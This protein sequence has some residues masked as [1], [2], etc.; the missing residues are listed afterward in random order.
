MT[1]ID[2]FASEL[3]E[4]A[5]ALFER[6]ADNPETGK[7]Y[8]HA[9]LMLGFCSFEAHINAISD[10]FLAARELSLADQSVLSERELKLERGTF[11]LGALKIHRLED[12]LQHLHATFGTRPVDRSAVWWGELA[13]ATRL[14]NSLTHPRTVPLIKANQAQRALLA[15][16]TALN[17]T[18]LSLYS[19]PFPT[20]TRGIQAKIV[21]P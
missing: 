3:L 11:K 9:S 2:E 13:D 16:I 10:D 6:G 15:I 12:R 18:Y 4:E 17:E 8:L 7:A 14:R 1:D 20:A 21:I 5:R 19:R